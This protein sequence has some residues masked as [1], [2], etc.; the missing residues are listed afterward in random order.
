MNDMDSIF[1]WKMFTASRCELTKQR[2][3]ARLMTG[4]WVITLLYIFFF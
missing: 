3:R 1:W 4:L 2:N